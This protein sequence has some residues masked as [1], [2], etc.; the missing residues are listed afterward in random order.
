MKKAEKE[1]IYE[2]AVRKENTGY[3]VREM[4]NYEGGRFSAIRVNA[5]STKE[6]ALAWL[7]NALSEK[8]E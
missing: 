1:T 2:Y 5:F 6:E 4:G 7:S 8:T 3:T